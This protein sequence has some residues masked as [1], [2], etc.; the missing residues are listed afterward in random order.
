MAG[1]RELLLFERD[2]LRPDDERLVLEIHETHIRENARI[3]G[4]RS[5]LIDITQRKRTGLA[6]Q[7][8]EKL[9]RHLVEHASDIIYRADIDGRFLIFNSLASKLLGYTSED[10]LGRSYLDLVKP[11]F[12]A[13]VRRFYRDQLT[14]R[15]AH[16]YLEF[17]AMAKDGSEVWLGENVEIMDN[18][19]PVVGSRA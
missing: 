16:T 15:L 2:Y 6:L 1:E 12:R 3:V 5:F 7:E 8:S 4:M 13:S 19:C 11:D 14:R 18:E 10:L 17:P 9:F